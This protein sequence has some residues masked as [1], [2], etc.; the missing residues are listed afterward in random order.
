[1]QKTFKNFIFSIHLLLLIVIFTLCFAF[2]AYF[3]VSVL[4]EKT[5]K[6]SDTIS[7]Q[8]YTSMYQVM[9][10]GWSRND[11]NNFSKTLNENFKDSEYSVHIYRNNN[12]MQQYGTVSERIKDDSVIKSLN[13]GK[14]IE[15]FENNI[16][17]KII[18]I[19]AK[20]EC[21]SCHK[22]VKVSDTLG[23]IDIETDLSDIFSELGTK[24]VWF[25]IFALFVFSIG[26]Y[27]SSRFT[28][29]KIVKAINS[30]QKRVEHID[31]IED[32]KQFKSSDVDLYFDEM[33]TIVKNVDSLAQKLKNIAVDKELLEFEVKLLDKF[34]ITSD[35]IQDWREFICDLL[36]EINKVMKTYTLMTVFRVGDDQYEIDIFWLGIPSEQIKKKY[37]DY[38]NDSIKDTE[39]F[40]GMS[41]FIIKHKVVNTNVHLDDALVQ[42]LLYR[43]KSL[44]L[45]TPKIGGIVGIGV[46]SQL[47]VDS[48]KGI[49]LDSILTTMA[50]LVGSVKAINKYTQDLEYY[51][52]RDPLT[53]LLNRRVFNDMLD[54]EIKRA[55]R[56]EYSFAVVLIDCDNFKYINDNYGHAF[57]DKYLQAI[58]NILESNKRDED[59]VAR[60]GG[61]EFI[62]ILPEC[63][64]NGAVATSE[65]I[66]N[67][68][69]SFELE[70]QNNTKVKV[71]MSMGISIYPDH[72]MNKVEL[73]AIADGM[74]FKAKEEGKNI[75]RTPNSNDIVNIIKNEKQKSSMLVS[76]LENEQIV[77]YFQPIKASYDETLEIRELLMRINIDGKIVSAFEFIETAEGMNLIN[78]MDLMVIKKAF[79]HVKS[80]DY[81]GL[82][83]INLSPK[84]LI[85]G[86]FINTINR[87]VNEYEI[88]R[89]NIVFEITERE[90]VKNFT[91]LEKFV[92]NLKSEGY[93]FAIDDFGSG[94]STFHYIKKFPIDYLK[95]DG[96]FIVNIKKD[97]KDK[98]F[99]RSIINLAHELEIKTIAEFVENDDVLAELKDLEIDYCQGFFIGKPSENLTNVV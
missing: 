59:I 37:E 46:H 64:I 97:K 89:E 82:L 72:A 2:S 77:P 14:T 83:F 65:R 63:E 43:T 55:K 96:D 74:M 49:V 88:N 35:V 54:Y 7:N 17:R 18:P 98:A 52:T 22:N 67:A 11:L 78:D 68:V 60:Y 66:L 71:T 75:L 93:K 32:F 48:V 61:D 81:K 34:I 76:A 20:Q 58:A 80:E 51:A 40:S 31:S 16:S 8:I 39:I 23:V 25:F 13:S 28:T 5:L 9:K 99:V 44:F 6:N 21:L 42:N 73:I 62:M 1:M 79:E 10:L 33:N 24:Y 12:V 3:F 87:L 38:I 92:S 41:S 4:N 50:N 95:I 70:T 84:S 90:T 85:A 94:F 19:H 69:R 15:A 45:D 30:F 56:H 29:E 47:E 91:L 57:G 53:N 27:I 26:A 86:N 36:F